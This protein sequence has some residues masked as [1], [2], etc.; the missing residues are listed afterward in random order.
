MPIFY[1]TSEPTP[2]TK[3]T[4]NN[5]TVEFGI[6][7][8]LFNKKLSPRYPQISTNINGSPKIGEPVLD[9]MVNSGSNTV[10]DNSP[11]DTFGITFKNQN[12]STNT[13]KNQNNQNDLESIEYIQDVN[14]PEFGDAEW[15]QGIQQYPQSS[16]DD[17][18]KYGIVGKTD[19]ALYRKD[20]TSKNLYLDVDEQTDATDSLSTKPVST[21][22]Q[23]PSYLIKYGELDYGGLNLGQNG[24]VQAADVIGSLLNGQGVGFS[25]TGLVTNFD[26]RSSLA[27]RALGLGGVLNDTELGIIGAQQLAIA[28]GNNAA[29]NIQEEILGSLNVGENILNLIKDGKAPAFRPNYQI[30]VPAGQLGRVADYTSRILG[31]TLPKSYLDIKGSIFQ[32]ESGSIDN[33]SRTNAMILNTG[34]GQIKALI[35]NVNASLQGIGELK[36][37]NST[38]RTGYAAGY[39]DNKGNKDNEFVIYAYYNGDGT[40]INPLSSSD[41]ILPDL[42]YLRSKKVDEEGFNEDSITTF[43]LG[44]T[45]YSSI[46]DNY[47]NNKINK[48]QFT[49]GS[50]NEEALNQVRGYTTDRFLNK[51]TMLGKTQQIFNSVGMKTIVSVKGESKDVNVSNLTES[52]NA[53]GISKGSAVIS[54]KFYEGGQYVYNNKRDKPENVYCRSW[55]SENRYDSVDNLIRKN[56]L[57]GNMPYRTGNF[58]P[59]LSVLDDNGFVKIGPYKEVEGK[60]ENGQYAKADVKKYMFSIENLAWS[61]NYSD[62]PAG[63]QGPGDSTTGKRGRIMWF[64]PYDITINENVSVDWE[65]TKFIGRGESVYTYNNTERSGTLGFSIIVDH[66]TY[67]N[68]LRDLPDDNYVASFFAGCVD[69]DDELIKKFLSLGQINQIIAKEEEKTA[70]IPEKEATPEVKPEEFTIYFPND[71]TDITKILGDGATAQLKRYENGLS[72]TTNNQIN[73]TDNST[74]YEQGVGTIDKTLY[75]NYNALVYNQDNGTYGANKFNNWVD[76]TN[77]GYNGWRKPINLN[78]VQYSGF[79]DPAFFPALVKHLNE[80]CKTCEINISGYASKQ[81]RTDTTTQETRDEYNI[82]VAK[83][84]QE[85]TKIYLTNELKKIDPNFD[86]TRIVTKNVTN[87]NIKEI[88]GCPDA[89]APDFGSLT[90][91][92]DVIKFTKINSPSNEACKL[93][94]KAIISFETNS[95]RVAQNIKDPETNQNTTTQQIQTPSLLSNKFYTELNFFEKLSR[96]T[97][98]SEATEINPTS[99]GSKLVFDKFREK[100]KHFHPAFHSTTPEG[101]NSRLTFLH[102]CTRQGPTLEELGATNLAFGRAPICILRIGD[103]YYT[104]IVIDSLSIDY[105]PIVWDLNPEGIGVQP[106]IAK[107]TLG[108]KFIGGSSLMGPINKLQNALSFNYYANTHVYDLRADYIEI[109][110]TAGNGTIVDGQKVASGFTTTPINTE[111]QAQNNV[112]SGNQVDKANNVTNGPVNE[113]PTTVPT[114]PIPKI[115]G[116]RGVYWLE[117]Q[118]TDF[119]DKNIEIILNEENVLSLADDKYLEFINKGIKI[120]VAEINNVEFTQKD[121]VIGGTET[122]PNNTKELFKNG[123]TIKYPITE[124]YNGKSFIVTV[125]YNNEKVGSNNL[126]AFSIKDNYVDLSNIVGVGVGKSINLP[127]AIRI[128]QSNATNDIRKQAGLNSINISIEEISRE[129]TIDNATSIYTVTIK[130]K[131]IKNK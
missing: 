76:I 52:I 78:G 80:V 12:I 34:R 88:K 8:F 29:F 33:V 14:N 101:L 16:N 96:G 25:D 103:F 72:A 54:G 128:A 119:G 37:S 18:K 1:N 9:T 65:A 84:R 22:Q 24:G 117:D 20:I 77:Y 5:I 126:S 130:L 62:L 122:N 10:P 44:D 70:P 95:E 125:S 108:F 92:G 6:R 3:N 28:L 98:S 50:S 59:E 105:E 2:N 87:E 91:N 100:I 112:G 99:E 13:F 94:R 56:G 4:I 35:S 110:D 79:T 120:S 116:I 39:T 89:N 82:G 73:Y 15:P 71:V 131:A 42:N 107:V 66:P 7:D 123:L 75:H 48:L 31:F 67:A 47:I 57:H 93:A 61:D 17:V 115:T 43:A 32:Y 36:T 64:P 27:G 53:Y 46:N 106:M 19:N 38:F 49:W 83:A 41:G 90:V 124:T 11:I 97:T 21:N 60:F 26:L 45:F 102:Q 40:L 23:R 114:T 81:F 85:S 104:K 51:K 69:P 121:I 74:G 68:T 86:V 55:T 127:T 129:E 111:Q 113:P 58:K 63:E 109:K 118:P 30:T